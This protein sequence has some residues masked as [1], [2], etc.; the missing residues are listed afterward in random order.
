MLTKYKTGTITYDAIGNPTSYYN[1]ARYALTWQGRQ[2]MTASKSGKTL[3]FSYNKDGIRTSKTVDGVEHIYY[4]NGTQ[5][6]AEEW[7]TNLLVYIYDTN[8]APIGMR[9]RRSTDTEGVWYTF[10]YEKNLQG[11]VIAV[12]NEQAPPTTK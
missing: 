2:L 9:Y 8:G 12:Y 1:G 6:L 3:S 10:W 11:D 4:I 7:D 5:I